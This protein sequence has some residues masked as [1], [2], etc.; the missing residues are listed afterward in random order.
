MKFKKI[1]LNIIVLI[2]SLF[3]SLI[4]LE[5]ILRFIVP[6]PL[7]CT[8][9]D[10]DKE[11][12][13]RNKANI[14]YLDKNPEYRVRYSTNN[15]GIRD[16]EILKSNKGEKELRI[17][18]IGDSFTY[19]LGL[20]LE[21]TFQF[22]LENKLK[23]NLN[24]DINVINAGVGGYGSKQSLELLRIEIENYQPDIV[25]F[26]FY[27]NDVIDD[28]RYERFIFEKNC[29]ISKDVGEVRKFLFFNSRTYIVYE[30][31]KNFLTQGIKPIRNA[32]YKIRNL[33]N[34]VGLAEEAKI[35]T[36]ILEKQYS[37][38]LKVGWSNTLGNIKEM[39]SL[40]RKNDCDFIL[41]YIPDRIQVNNDFR[42]DYLIRNNLN[43]ENFNF[44]KPSII[45]GN[46]SKKNRII[47]I[48][49]ME[50]FNKLNIDYN[51]LSVYYGLDPHFNENGAEVWSDVLFEKIIGMV[52]NA[53]K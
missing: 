46:F 30:T 16:S 21:E 15:N 8:L 38:D 51:R 3:I 12:V 27:N 32:L 20:N 10:E 7:A 35:G 9:L 33:L 1:L 5:I 50:E 23:D 2:A 49:L 24:K 41:V 45:L 25:L 47:Y 13:Y 40:C 18:T 17:F 29:V 44:Q 48:D 36:P 4:F 53:E 22:K 14:D 34:I 43:K 39:K 11:L 6:L 31:Y 28:T 42:K 19:G 37:D 52:E 26:S